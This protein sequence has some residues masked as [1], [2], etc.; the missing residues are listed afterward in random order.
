MRSAL[1]SLRQRL[2]RRGETDVAAGVIFEWSE[3]GHLFR[4]LASDVARVAATDTA[5]FFVPCVHCHYDWRENPTLPCRG[6][7]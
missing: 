5:Q 6:E 1:Q 2:R 3:D 7:R 4:L